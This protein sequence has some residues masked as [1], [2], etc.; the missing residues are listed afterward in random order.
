MRYYAWRPINCKL[1][2]E[3]HFYYFIIFSNRSTR[4]ANRVQSCQHHQ[5]CDHVDMEEELWRWRSTEISNKIQEGHDGS[6]LQVHWD[7]TGK[8][9]YH[10]E[11]NKNFESNL[12]GISKFFPINLIF[13]QTDP[14]PKNKRMLSRSSWTIWS[15]LHAMWST[16][17]RWTSLAPR[18]FCESR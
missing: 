9:V 10:L 7:W 3:A 17:N 1:L 14:I 15:R 18:V 4:T 6:H 12:D 5:K 16:S 13:H 11:Y 8:Y 2:L